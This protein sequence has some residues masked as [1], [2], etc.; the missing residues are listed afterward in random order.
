MRR[1][2]GMSWL[3]SFWMINGGEVDSKKRRS[4]WSGNGRAQ[5]H[6]PLFFCE[7]AVVCKN[8]GDDLLSPAKDYHRP[9]MLNGRVRN[10]N[11]WDHPGMLT[12]NTLRVLL[13]SGSRCPSCLLHD[14]EIL[15]PLGGVLRRGS[16]RRSVRL[17]V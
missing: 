11:G 13:G 4:V 9:R 5:G 16:M 3:L 6:G 15:G 2:S 14:L 8:P 17:L 7:G 12:G 1:H 10:G